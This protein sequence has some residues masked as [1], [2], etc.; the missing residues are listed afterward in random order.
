MEP[1]SLFNQEDND[2]FSAG[3]FQQRWGRFI[4][5]NLSGTRRAI[6]LFKC[7]E[8]RIINLEHHPAKNSSRQTRKQVVFRKA[9][10]FYFVTRG[11]DLLSKD[12][13]SHNNCKGVTVAHIP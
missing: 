8:M 5:K 4:I 13:L 1:G 2:T 9:N 12:S 3:E 6:T 10:N 11:F 7:C